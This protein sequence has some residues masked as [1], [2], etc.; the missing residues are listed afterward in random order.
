MEYSYIKMDNLP[1]EILLIILKELFNV[2]VLY[3]LIDV[4]HID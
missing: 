2:E 3:S 1:D 4:N